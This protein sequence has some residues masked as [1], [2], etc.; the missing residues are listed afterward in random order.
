M[1][2]C[3]CMRM[4]AKRS[5][6]FSAGGAAVL[7]SVCQPLT[8]TQTLWRRGSHVGCTVVCALMTG[9]GFLLLIADKSFATGAS[10]ASLGL[11]RVRCVCLS[12]SV[13]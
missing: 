8:I 2:A 9:A 10:S 5:C 3:C 11:R 1:G 12:R 7:R 6:A 13:L 4:R